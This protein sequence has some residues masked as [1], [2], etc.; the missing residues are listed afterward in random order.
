M[1]D[2][3][4]GKQIRQLRSMANGLKPL[5]IIGKE[6]VTSGVAKQA[7]EALEARELVKCS[8]LDAC[9]ME[10]RDAAQQLANMTE[11]HVVQVIGHKF[12]LYR[13]SSRD[14]IEKIELV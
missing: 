1:E 2:T 7:G 9:G 3:L 12:T 5:V 4:T 10:A 8:V 14:D 11:A 13:E 6:G